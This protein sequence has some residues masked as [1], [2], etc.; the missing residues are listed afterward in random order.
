MRPLDTAAPTW[1][2]TGNIFKHRQP[3]LKIYFIGSV[4]FSSDNVLNGDRKHWPGVGVRELKT[5]SV[6]RPLFEVVA[7]SDG[8]HSCWCQ[9]TPWENVTNW[10][11]I[12]SIFHRGLTFVRKLVLTALTVPT[13]VVCKYWW[14]PQER[15]VEAEIIEISVSTIRSSDQSSCQSIRFP[16]TLNRSPDPAHDQHC[17][18]TSSRS[19]HW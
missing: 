13:C 18:T 1:D 14:W 15:P 16:T 6:S 10:L 7:L 8:D 19:P 2:N 12:I 5:L 3:W 9:V 17:V 4:W 11:K